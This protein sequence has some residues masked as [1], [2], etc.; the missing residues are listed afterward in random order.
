MTESAL[1]Q[2]ITP[3]PR[4]GRNLTIATVVGVALLALVVLALTVRKD[5]FVLIAIV[6]CALALRELATA[7]AAR[8][9]HVPLLPLLVGS[10]GILV[11]SYTAGT[12]ALLVSFLLTAGG[13]V[14]WR[15][16]DGGGMI[17]MRDASA[18]TFAAAYIPFLAGFVMLMLSEND[19]ARRV[20]LFILLVVA[21]D[22]G[23]YAA[24]SLVGR[25]RMAPRISPNKT[26]EGLVGSVI[27]AVSVGIVAGNI[28]LHLSIVN[29]VIVAVATVA[30]ATLG[31]LAESSIK[32]DLAL[33]DMG[34]L[35]P[36][37]GGVLDRLD[38][39]LVAAPV[40]YLLLL[41]LHTP[42]VS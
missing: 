31:D 2:R 20:L 7:L 12:E 24:G 4:G 32:R 37:H 3:A 25:H 38:S 35:L 26:W 28:L 29:A 5:T 41:I 19:G 42:G 14:V 30:T 15:V 10:V 18:G 22:V 33:K 21:N 8:G 11:S 16:I 13:V 27:L 36:G 40:T 23:G 17:A 1:S 34:D 6:A 39:M 9:I